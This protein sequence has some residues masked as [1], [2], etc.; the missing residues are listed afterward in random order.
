MT[1]IGRIVA[2]ILTALLILSGGYNLIQ[3]IEV[4]H[5]KDQ[6]SELKI[7]NANL[8]T[9]IS[10]CKGNLDKQNQAVADQGRTTKEKQDTINDLGKQLADQQ[11][12]NQAL[13][14]KL[15]KQQAPKTCQDAAKYL[16]DSL[17]DY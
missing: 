10:N 6:V 12:T 3:H 1:L 17:G 13:I 8:N 2:Y 5:Y 4:D 11:K 15:S 16:K 14:G 9:E 7:T